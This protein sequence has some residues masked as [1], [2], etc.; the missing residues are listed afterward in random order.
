MVQRAGVGPR[1]ESKEMWEDGQAFVDLQRRKAQLAPRTQS[2]ERQRKQLSAAKRIS[3]RAA[4]AAASGGGGGAAGAY[5]AAPG[6]GPE[7]EYP[8][9]VVERVEFLKASDVTASRHVTATSLSGFSS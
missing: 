8:L 1:S 9:D 5:L 7:T 3:T 2:L 4:A 6:G